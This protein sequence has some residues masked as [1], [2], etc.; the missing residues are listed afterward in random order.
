[1][2]VYMWMYGYIFSAMLW[3]AETEPKVPPVITRGEQRMLEDVKCVPAPE[4]NSLL[5]VT[6]TTER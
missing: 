4:D 6:R 5:G 3:L 1:M 2:H